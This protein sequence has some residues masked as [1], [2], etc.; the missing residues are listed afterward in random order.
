MVRMFIADHLRRQPVSTCAYLL[1]SRDRPV[2]RAG[3]EIITIGIFVPMGVAVHGESIACP[4]LI[5]ES[6]SLRNRACDRGCRRR[7]LL[8][9][10]HVNA[11]LHDTGFLHKIKR[12]RTLVN[13]HGH[14]DQ[15]IELDLE[16]GACLVGANL[17]VS[18]N[19]ITIAGDRPP[20]ANLIDQPGARFVHRIRP[21]C[22]LSSFMFDANCV[23]IGIDICF[24]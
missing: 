14:V 20:P 7:C 10:I 12:R 13:S 6:L 19:V 11:S 15:L 18:D 22:I 4:T 9:N 21:G 2:G 16:S 3:P 23:P 17:A 5:S 1:E 24:Q 8:P